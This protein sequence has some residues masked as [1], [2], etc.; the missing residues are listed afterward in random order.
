MND[1][2][3][4]SHINFSSATRLAAINQCKPMPASLLN[5]TRYR[6]NKLVTF[7]M[8]LNV[9][10]VHHARRSTLGW[11]LLRSA[12][13]GRVLKSA[14]AAPVGRTVLLPATGCQRGQSEAPA[15]ILAFTQCLLHCQFKTC[16]HIVVP[17]SRRSLFTSC[18]CTGLV[19]VAQQS[20]RFSSRQQVRSLGPQ[21]PDFGATR[22]AI[23]GLDCSE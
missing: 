5:R 21:L 4:P 10:P 12:L 2:K 11:L 22:V 16:C 14:A 23:E 7:M 9:T 3:A 20:H 19:P 17:R 13:A 6:S 18:H 15:S 8:L 1:V